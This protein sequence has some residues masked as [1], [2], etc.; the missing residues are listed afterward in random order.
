MEA[1]ATLQFKQCPVLL[2]VLLKFCSDIENIW[3]ASS[4]SSQ[5]FK[6]Q[7]NNNIK[8]LRLQCSHFFLSFLIGI[9]VEHFF[10]LKFTPSNLVLENS[11][12]TISSKGLQIFAFAWCLWQAWVILNNCS[13]T[14]SAAHLESKI[15]LNTHMP[16]TFENDQ[17]GFGSF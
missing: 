4:I 14:G 2:I 3:S 7:N 13:I 5:R 15:S 11:C 8:T 17:W 6:Q 1:C 16:Y 12:N 9:K 10:V